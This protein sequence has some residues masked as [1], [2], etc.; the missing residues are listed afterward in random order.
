MINP[1][2]DKKE[3]AADLLSYLFDVYSG[4]ENPLDGLNA[5]LAESGFSRV[6][7]IYPYPE[8]ESAEGVYC[9]TVFRPWSVVEPLFGAYNAA[10]NGEV[11]KEGDEKAR[12]G[13]RDEDGE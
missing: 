7:L 11:E 12:A 6:P 3:Q 1:A 4:S 5:F 9:E 10:A 8:A 2:S 13:G